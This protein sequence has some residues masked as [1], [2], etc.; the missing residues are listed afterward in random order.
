VTLFLQA[1]AKQNQNT[2]RAK[3]K[4]KAFVTDKNVHGFRSLKG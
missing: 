1:F 4:Q 3:P 2:V